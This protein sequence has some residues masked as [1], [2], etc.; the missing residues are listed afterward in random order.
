[1]NQENK[2]GEI[3]EKLL[4]YWAVFLTACGK[5]WNKI[6]VNGAAL[7]DWLRRNGRVLLQKLAAWLLKAKEWLVKVTAE[8]RA[9]GKAAWGDLSVW[10]AGVGEKLRP[11]P[12]QIK[13]WCTDTIARLKSGKPAKAV[14]ELP[15]PEEPNVLPEAVE[16][17]A[18]EPPAEKPAD[19][20]EQIGNPYL[21][22]A[23]VILAA[24]GRGIRFALKW[25]WK[26]RTI[27][28]AIPVLWAAI[29]LAM[30]NMD[31]LPEQVGLDIQST[32]E[33]ARMISRTEAVYW[34]L[35]IT[36]FCLVLMFVSKK[37]ML[38]WVISIFTLILPWLIWILNYIA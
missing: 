17:P 9:K 8:L 27:F 11:I 28:M 3:K 38:P 37:P 36:I 24:V 22:K 31:R 18:E 21:R 32:G 35:G 19:H 5:L 12:G 10:L 25:I 16:V 1:M 4:Q 23:L 15:A 26:L 13:T 6:K 2:F 7:W 34:P 33:F 29:K 14:E 20:F 30:Q